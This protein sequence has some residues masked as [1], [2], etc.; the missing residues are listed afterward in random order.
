MQHSIALKVAVCNPAVGV[1]HPNKGAE[2][3]GHYS[4]AGKNWQGPAVA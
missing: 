2:H 3:R 1:S 4:L